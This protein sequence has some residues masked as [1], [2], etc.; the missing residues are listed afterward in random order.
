MAEEN[1]RSMNMN[2][3]A[4]SGMPGGSRPRS[5]PPIG[6]NWPAMSA[7][8]PP[9]PFPSFTMHNSDDNNDDDDEKEQAVS[10]STINHNIT[11]LP[12]AG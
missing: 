9:I 1:A 8:R 6:M 3:L 12:N 11:I 2:R 4:Q 5:G 10:T 7:L